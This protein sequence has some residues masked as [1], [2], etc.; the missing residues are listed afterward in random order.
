MISQ[1]RNKYFLVFIISVIV[2]TLNITSELIAHPIDLNNVSRMEI[3][4]VYLQMG[5]T[6]ILPYG[7]D[8]ILFIFGIYLLSPNLKTVLIQATAFTIAHT[9]TLTL[10]TYD[11]ITFQSS[12]IEPIISLSIMFIAIENIFA[13]EI[14]P[15]RVIVIFIFG[16]IHGMGFASVLKDLGLPK[17]EFVTAL[18]TFT[19]GVELGQI[20]VIMIA[21][22]FIGKWFAAKSWYHS[23]IVTG[24]S[25][26]IAVIALYWT[27]ERIWY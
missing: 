15:W 9:I 26:M 5:F 21:Y 25:V 13:K 27:V 2:L 3:G 19:L 4:W 12:L 23:R 16:L 22:Y 6:H 17:T 14:K 10:S 24:L 7:L 1:N 18:V 20:T 8:H 11:I